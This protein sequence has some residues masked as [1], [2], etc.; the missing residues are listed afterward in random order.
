[1]RLDNSRKKYA[2][3]LTELLIVVIII[4]V[5][6]AF[7]IP[8][9]SRSIERSHRRDAE[10]Q[11]T[12]IW[13]ANQVYR[14][15]YGS[16]W[17]PNNNGGPGYDITAIN[18]NLGLGIIPNGMTYNCTS[19]AANTFTCTAV[20]QPASSFTITVTQAQIGGSN[21]ACTAGTCP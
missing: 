11:L 9:Y 20:R 4:S 7:T 10:T 1:M 15:Q 6:A 21:P 17:P 18:S 3:T 8:N 19:V 2:F 5:M 13:S 12:T 16:Y 14:A